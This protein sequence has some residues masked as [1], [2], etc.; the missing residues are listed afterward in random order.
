M[1]R[2]ERENHSSS[3]TLGEHGWAPGPEGARF[4]PAGLV[5]ATQRV[6]ETAHVVAAPTGHIGVGFAGLLEGS[7]AASG[8]L[9]W[10]GSLA[11]L[12]PEWLGDRAFCA[13][14]GVRFPYIAGAMAN[15]I[16]TVD[17][18]VEMAR[19]GMIG[20]YGAAG[21]PPS[22]VEAALDAIEARI[23][24]QGLPFG[25]NLIHSPHEPRIEAGVVDLYLRRGVRRVSASAYMDLTPMIVRYAAT[26]LSVDAEGRVQRRNHV[27][28]KIS[29][30]EVAARFMSPAPAALLQRLVAEG[31]LKPEEARLAAQVPVAEDV[32]VE[33]DSGG[34]T[35]NQTLTAVFPVIVRLRDELSAR[36]GYSRPIRV[37]AAG[38]LGTPHAVAAAFA[39]GAAYVLTGSVNQSAVESGLSPAGK[40]LLAQASLDDAM[41][42][43][44]ADMFEMGVKVQVL[45]RGTMFGVRAQKLYDLYRAYPSLD[46]IPAAERSR[47]E[48]DLF[49]LPLDEV[50]RQTERFFA[51][52]DPSQNER[53]SHDE[54]HRMA[55]VF[56]WYLGQS[57]RWAIQGVKGRE[58][59]YQIWSGPALG[60]FNSWVKGSFLE[61]PEHRTVVQ[62]ARNLL[63]GAAVLTRAHQL[64]TF[65]VAVPSEAFA[66]TPRPLS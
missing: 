7:P 59:D 31:L 45:R 26:G 29:R 4:D 49:Q 34:H 47:L 43:P 25:M 58:L 42:A 2:T 35:D 12:Y 37:G 55:L 24:P 52:R 18:V 30:P 15:G 3:A 36:Y 16:C 9:R 46:A 11:P 60:A 5:E 27:F 23:G 48:R 54:K 41:M 50:W 62:I 10:L 38:G 51:D 63:E 44:A 39:L 8:T 64:R 19:A 20:F 28:A 66:W 61:R 65:G 53:A 13:A 21:L 14:H 40:M 6:R 57:S 33:A 1:Y 56:R 17:I 32:T 22:Q